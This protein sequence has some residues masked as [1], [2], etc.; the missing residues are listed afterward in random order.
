MLF[1]YCPDVVNQSFSV[2]MMI[3]MVMCTCATG[4]GV[5]GT[6]AVKEATWMLTVTSHVVTWRTE[7]SP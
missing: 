3:T 5:L 7:L 4:E 1:G 6:G 2:M